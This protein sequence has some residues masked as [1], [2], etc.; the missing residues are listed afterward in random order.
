MFCLGW[1]EITASR[2]SAGLESADIGEPPELD[3]GAGDDEEPTSTLGN[4]SLMPV[5][6]RQEEDGVKA[7]GLHGPGGFQDAENKQPTGELPSAG[8]P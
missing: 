3:N 2:R 1:T 7:T 4:T 5:S 8:R 6:L